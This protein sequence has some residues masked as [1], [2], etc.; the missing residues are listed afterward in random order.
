MADVSYW[1]SNIIDVRKVKKV[2][3]L[4]IQ[5]IDHDSNGLCLSLMFLLSQGE[6]CASMQV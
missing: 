5:D 3:V 1:A 2:S 4:L 6:K